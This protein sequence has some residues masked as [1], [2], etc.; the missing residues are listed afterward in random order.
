M[1]DPLECY[2]GAAPENKES[3]LV[4]GKR[5]KV[6]KFEVIKPIDTKGRRK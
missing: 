4:P 2:V 6:H 5:L 3:H 1:K